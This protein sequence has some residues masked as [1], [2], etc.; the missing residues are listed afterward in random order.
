MSKY[1]S[2]NICEGTSMEPLD[3]LEDM[4]ACFSKIGACPT[5]DESCKLRGDYNR[6]YK[7][8]CEFLTDNQQQDDSETQ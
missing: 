4:A 6:C 7:C 1:K 2:Q 3:I 8:W 5:R